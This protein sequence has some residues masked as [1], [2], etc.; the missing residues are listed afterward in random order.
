MPTGSLASRIQCNPR[1]EG[2]RL[3]N[4]VQKE[5]HYYLFGISDL[6]TYAP[7]TD[8][9]L[10][11]ATRHPSPRLHALSFMRSKASNCKDLQGVTYQSRSSSRSTTSTYTGAKR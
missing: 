9:M 2:S 11:D 5:F 4:V 10:E 8:C 6:C 3:L 1:Y 7:Y